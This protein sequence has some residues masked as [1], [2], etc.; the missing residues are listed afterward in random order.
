MSVKTINNY[1][2][3]EEYRDQN[4]SEAEK[5][6]KDP[7]FQIK[8][9]G[10]TMKDFCDVIVVEDADN[11]KDIYKGNKLLVESHLLRKLNDKTFVLPINGVVA[12][13]L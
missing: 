4:G 6:E 7:I 2:I 11:D 13:Y 3:V 10:M 12:I 5:L 9:K 8:K 1:L